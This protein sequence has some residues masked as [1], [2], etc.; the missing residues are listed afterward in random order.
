MLRLLVLLLLAHADGSLFLPPLEGKQGPEIALISVQGASSPVEGYKPAAE[1]IQKASPFKVWVG[2]PQYLFDLPELQFAAK[3]DDILQQMEK[4][5]MKA[6]HKVIMGHSL[7]AVGC[8]GYIAGK[9]QGK[10]DALVLTG[11]AVL[12]KYRNSTKF[13][14]TLT[15]D[16]DLDGLLRIT[17]QA[18]A[19]FH[20]VIKV[21]GADAP[22]MDRPVVLLE[23]VDHWSFS[24]GDRP[25]N[26]KKNDI[27]AEVTVEEGHAMIGEVIADYMSSLFGSDAE[28]AAAGAKIVEAVKKTGEL[29]EPILAAMHLEGYHNLNPPC[30]SDYPTNPTCQYAKYP[31]KSLLPPA[32]PPKPMPPADCT[33]GSDWVANTAANMVAGFEKT[34]ASQTKLVTKDAFH[35]VSDVRPFHLPHIFEP[36][37]GTACSDPATCVINATTVSM[38]IYDW[39][40]DFDVGLW[41]I[42]ASEFR[43][44]FK[45]REALQQAAGLQDV[46]YTA[47]D[48]LNTEICKSINQAAYDWALKTA[49]SKARDR[50]LKH[51]QP[52]VFVEDKKSGFG[53]TGPT[54]IHDALSFTPSQDKKTVAV[55]SHYFPLKN[56]NLGDVSFV[57]T[58]GYH[59][60][61][62]LSPARAMEWIYVDGLKEFYGTRDDQIQIVV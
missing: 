46:N 18:E 35:D 40:D 2:I 60:C 44:K 14:P 1:A 58:V 55:Q 13:P 5:G 50:F 43:T 10:M 36:Q 29:V 9:G 30:N 27:Q 4:A 53:I 45:S 28:K 54:W 52:Y 11:A 17:R 25:S 39:K 24:S 51:G 26:V 19:Y 59:Y 22:G 31:D 6:D 37:P 56:K 7:G 12:R 47:T 32:G 61:K 62:L 16:G 38:P 20:Q 23:G 41:P 8:Q 15:L 21:G 49:S 57:Q 48:E 33:C 34:P 42:T 3:V